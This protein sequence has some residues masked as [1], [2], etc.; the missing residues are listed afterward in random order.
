MNRFKFHTH[1]Y[2][3]DKKILNSGVLV[4]VS[5]YNEYESDYY[6]LLNE[7]LEFKCFGVNNKLILF[8]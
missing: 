6:D 3:S 7:A 1:D 2:D 8:K 4:K 5:S